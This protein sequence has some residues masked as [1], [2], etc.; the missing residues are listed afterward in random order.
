M[1][2][3]KA[4]TWEL[5]SNQMISVLKLPFQSWN[6]HFQK[7]SF[8]DWKNDLKTVQNKLLGTG[9]S[10]SKPS[11]IL[12]KR[13][14]PDAASTKSHIFCTTNRHVGSAK[15]MC[16]DLRRQSATGVLLKYVHVRQQGGLRSNLASKRS[17][18]LQKKQYSA[19]DTRIILIATLRI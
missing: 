12:K 13:W 15:I 7:R 6:G 16:G 3:K 1:H 11:P 9:P 5:L 14:T 8:W 10:H 2:F 18:F 17:I 19:I 4:T